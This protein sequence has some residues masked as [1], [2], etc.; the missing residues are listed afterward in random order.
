[1]IPLSW[2]NR[3]SVLTIGARQG[4]FPGM[5]ERRRFDVVIVDS[6]HGVGPNVTDAPNSVIEYD[7][8]EIQ[9]TVR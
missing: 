7:G 6:G 2:D 9:K 4:S 1:V 5:I 8:K 3:N